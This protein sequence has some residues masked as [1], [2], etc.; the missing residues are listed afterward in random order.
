MAM[1]ETQR[2]IRMYFGLVGILSTFVN[3]MLLLTGLKA[4]SILLVLVSG[5]GCLISLSFLV[6]AFILPNV[7][8]NG[9]LIPKAALAANCLYLLGLI[10]LFMMVLPP[11]KAG[12]E[13]VK[14]IIGLLISWYLWA[15]I[16]RLSKD[17]DGKLA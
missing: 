14:P 12:G 6:L 16:S 9:A 4:A 5:L 11:E 1:Q 17:H 2:S 3:A 7:I 8:G 13:A 10:A 15:N